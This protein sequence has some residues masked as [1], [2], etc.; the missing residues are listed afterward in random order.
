MEKVVI[1]GLALSVLIGGALVAGSPACG[2]DAK[3]ELC[4]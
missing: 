2:I 3:E 1:R 4:A